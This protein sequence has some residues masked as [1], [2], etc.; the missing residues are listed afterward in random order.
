MT[1]RSVEDE[2]NPD[3]GEP[4]YRFTLANERT[5]LA[6]VRTALAL[7]AAGVAAVQFLT[8]VEETWIRRL[9][10]IVLAVAGIGASVGAYARWRANVAAIREHRPLPPT[11]MPVG[12]AAAA[13]VVSLVAVYLVAFGG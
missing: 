11:L 4:D 10:G 12:L 9:I 3:P 5:F 2:G 7:D 6:Y 13:L 8:S 1:A